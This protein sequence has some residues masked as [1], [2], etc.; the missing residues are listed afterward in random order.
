MKRLDG[1]RRSVGSDA[2]RNTV[3]R[4]ITCVQ[5]HRGRFASRNAFP[6]NNWCCTGKTPSI[7]AET[8]TSWFHPSCKHSS[9]T[10][11]PDPLDRR[12]IVVR[13]TVGSSLAP[14]FS[15]AVSWATPRTMFVRE[16]PSTISRGGGKTKGHRSL[17]KL[18]ASSCSSVLARLNSCVLRQSALARGSEEDRSK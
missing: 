4:N 5:H 12:F 8:S 7:D 14:G 11:F 15:F 3:T 9:T 16:G 13:C 17:F 1:G 18:H 2:G 10:C 6:S